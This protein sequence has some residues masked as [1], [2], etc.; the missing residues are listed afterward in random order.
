MFNQYNIFQNWKKGIREIKLGIPNVGLFFKKRSSTS[1]HLLLYHFR[2]I[3]IFLD[4]STHNHD[5]VLDEYRY[6]TNGMTNPKKL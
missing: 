3:I 4:K 6:I 5:G 2:D 1:D